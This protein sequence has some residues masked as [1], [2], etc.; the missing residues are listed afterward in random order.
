[1]ISLGMGKLTNY[2][3]IYV[4][5]F[6]VYFRIFYELYDDYSITRIGNTSQT[7]SQFWN[8]L[9]NYNLINIGGCQQ[10]VNENDNILFAF[11]AFNKK[12]CLK[13]QTLNSTSKIGSP[14]MVKVTDGLTNQP[15]QGAMIE[16]QLTDMNGFVTLVFHSLGMRKLKAERDDSIRSNT[17]EIY[18]TE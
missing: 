5:F 13:L 12:H 14:F 11:D 1:M 4:C 2:L 6:L 15:I 18:I 3:F 7:K 16:N 8:V 17:I 9:I 10:K